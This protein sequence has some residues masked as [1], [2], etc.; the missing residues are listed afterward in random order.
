MRTLDEAEKLRLA[1]LSIF[2]KINKGDWYQY[3]KEVEL[4]KIVKNS[5]QKISEI[6]DKAKE[7]IDEAR[8]LLEDFLPNLPQSSEIYF[9]IIALEYPNRF[10]VGENTFINSGLQIISAG[11]VKIGK[12]CFIGPN[13]QLFT[14][15]HHAR[16]VFLRREGWQYDG[17]IV[18]GNDCWLGGSVILLPGVS[19]GDDVV[20]GAGSVVTK[21]FPSH[22]VIAGNPARLIRNK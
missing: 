11:K 1:K 4:Q 16:D 12:N 3:S 9:P 21:S 2:D 18:I 5:S 22:C 13:C 14:P 20:V 8:K 10:K 15:N 19:L 6:N 7:N 17:P